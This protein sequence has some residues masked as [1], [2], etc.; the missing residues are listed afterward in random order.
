VD[1]VVGA[2]TGLL[3]AIDRLLVGSIVSAATERT[4]AKLR[5]EQQAVWITAFGKGALAGDRGRRLPPPDPTRMRSR[6]NPD[7]ERTRSP[8][9]QAAFA[10]AA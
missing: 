1:A 7:L 10:A 6:C 4:S 5:K 2:V 8:E 9:Q 3:V